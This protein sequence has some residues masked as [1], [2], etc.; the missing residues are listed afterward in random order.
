MVEGT[1]LWTRIT[2]CDASSILGGRGFFGKFMGS[3]Q[4][5]IVKNLGSFWFVAVIPLYTTKNGWGTQRVDHTSL[6]N[7][8]NRS[9]LRT[10]GSD[11][12]SQLSGLGPQWAVAPRIIV[13]SSIDIKKFNCLYSNKTI[14]KH[15]EE[16]SKFFE[17]KIT[18]DVFACWK[19]E[20][21]N[22]PSDRHAFLCVCVFICLPVL[23][24]VGHRL[25]VLEI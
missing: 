18:K 8:L 23:S 6:L 9:P 1:L 5:S 17:G 16:L 12:S 4:T 7:S 11:T 21:L 22:L 24:E 13:I 19:T 14:L 2:G 25:F 20:S 10:N 3:V 15:T